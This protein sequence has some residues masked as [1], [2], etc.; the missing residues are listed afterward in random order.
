MQRLQ[1]R[2]LSALDHTAVV[3]VERRIYP[4]GMQERAE[5]IAARLRFEDERYSS[6]NL[7]LFDGDA[8]VGYVLA[9]LDDGAEFRDAGIG[10]NIYI[11]DL[12]VLSLHRRQL[13]QLMTAL[14]REARLEYPGL[15]LVAHAIGTTGDAT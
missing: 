10:D 7:G 3:A 15:P 4:S 8:L 12:A 2:R 5:L 1:V 14:A 13:V 11:A 6:L 9:H